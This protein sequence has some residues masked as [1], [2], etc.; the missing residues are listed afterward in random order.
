M[1]ILIEMKINEI[2]STKYSP[3][4]LQTIEDFDCQY[5]DVQ[6]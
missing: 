5:Y 4:D 3:S 2:L 1:D 6:L